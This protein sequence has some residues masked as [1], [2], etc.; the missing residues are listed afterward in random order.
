MFTLF[1]LTFILQ[2]L[3]LSS[4]SF[5]IFQ[6]F[7]PAP[8]A[9]LLSFSLCIVAVLGNVLSKLITNVYIY[10]FASVGIS[11]L[12]A[13]IIVR[14]MSI[15]MPLIAIFFFVILLNVNINFNTGRDNVDFTIP[16]VLIFNV[17]L[18]LLNENI[19]LSTLKPYFNVLIFIS[20]IS[21]VILLIVRQ[22]NTSRTF[23]KRSMNISK[24]QKKNNIIFATVTIV[25]LLIISSFG[26]VSDIFKIIGYIFL[27]FV[28]LLYFLFGSNF[29]GKVKEAP[30]KE[31]Q[32]SG[33]DQPFGIFDWIFTILAGLLIIIIA[34]FIVFKLIKS[35]I[36]L[37]KRIIAWFKD[38]EKAVY[39]FAE[40]GHVDEKTNIL[41]KN[42]NKMAKRL[43]D[44]IGGLFDRE[45][46]YRKL[47]ND[48]LRVRRL[49]K[50]FYEDVRK[51]RLNI[52]NSNTAAEICSKVS[53][54]SPDTLQY[55]STMSKCYDAARYG[56]M[57]PTP[58]ELKLLERKYRL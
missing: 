24:F 42:I 18:A 49:F 51:S 45:V 9:I 5:A 29:N 50:Y 38:G 40:D 43:R 28:D 22:I 58:E 17:F 44:R 7:I 3:A 33:V 2:Y 8:W 26:R 57:N 55:N 30:V 4:I 12:S 21:V 41:N 25:L 54:S 13:V 34:G 52:K 53:E 27:K 36:K 37:T 56:N 20:T 23:A 31:L 14:R 16:I 10:R 35:I 11:I 39:Q 15:T 19:Q 32:A 46:P 1:T 6:F 48:M 47:Q